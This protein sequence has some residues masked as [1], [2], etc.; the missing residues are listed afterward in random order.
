METESKSYQV[1]VNRANTIAREVSLALFFLAFIG[2]VLLYVIDLP[3]RHSAA[4][5]QIGYY[6]NLPG[7]VSKIAGL[8]AITGLASFLF[9]SIK[10]NVRAIL[11]IT[12]HKAEFNSKAGNLFIELDKLKRIVFIKKPY[13]LKP[14]RIEFIYSTKKVIRI[15][16]SSEEDF[17]EIANQLY[18]ATPEHV[19]M[20]KTLIETED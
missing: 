11:K 9:H 4:D 19:G 1:Y 3:V 5:I 12:Q 2:F 14:Y 15:K 8:T 16:I 20:D 17:Y 7:W 6:M 18:V 13:S 10:S